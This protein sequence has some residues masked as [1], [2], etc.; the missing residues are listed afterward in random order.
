MERVLGEELAVPADEDDS[1]GLVLLD[2]GEDGG[3]GF[4]HG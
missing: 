2:L 1:R 4:R 3:E